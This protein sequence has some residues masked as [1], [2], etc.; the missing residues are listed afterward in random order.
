MRIETVVVA[1]GLL[2]VTLAGCPAS[3]RA[4][5]PVSTTST[6][7]AAPEGAP[8]SSRAYRILADDSLLQ[9]VVRKGGA[10]AVAGHNHVIASRHLHGMLDLREPLT[11]SRFELVVPV[12]LLTVDEPA[13]RAPRGDEFSSQVSDSA[14]EGT[15][16]NMLGPASLDAERYP[17][18]TITSVALSGGP[19]D[20]SARVALQVKGRTTLVDIP[21]RVE[22]SDGRVRASGQFSVD[23]TALGLEP[24][25]A[26]MGAL[27]VKDRLDIEFVVV[28]AP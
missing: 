6:P 14:R 10:L 9:V 20:F 1:I 13:L 25:S 8:V 16:K 23:Q 3:R 15:R 17:G 7:P 18:I 5:E 24:F 22:Q 12:S 26:F 2:A 11:S 21:V 19:A 27:Q 4:A 28:A